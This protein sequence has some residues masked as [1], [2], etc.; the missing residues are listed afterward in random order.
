MHHAL[1]LSEICFHII[2]EIDLNGRNRALAVLARTCRRFFTPALKELW[3]ELDNFDYLLKLLPAD[4]WVDVT[5]DGKE[6]KVRRHVHIMRL[7][8]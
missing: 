1:I 4:L 8:F 5:R 3:R 6:V 2:E 7:D